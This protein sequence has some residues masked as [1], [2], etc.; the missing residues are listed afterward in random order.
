[1]HLQI[2]SSSTLVYIY[3]I[4]SLHISQKIKFFISALQFTVGIN[5]L[6]QNIKFY[7]NTSMFSLQVININM[8]GV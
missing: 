4:E 7:I 6:T 3:Q 1:M 2:D 8:F 5:A